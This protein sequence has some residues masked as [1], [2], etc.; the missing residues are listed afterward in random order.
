MKTRR[1]H[2]VALVV[3][4]LLVGALTLI[5]GPAQAHDELVS[6]NPADRATVAVMPAQIVLTFAEAAEKVG[7]QVIVK[8]PG[9]DV[10]VGT[11]VFSGVTVTQAVQPGAPAGSYTVLWRV[12]SDDGH[13]VSG[14]FG[15]TAA[16]AAAT[17]S[18]AS[19][20]ASTAPSQGSTG[21]SGGSGGSTWVKVLVVLVLLV[22]IALFIRRRPGRRGQMSTH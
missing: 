6:T 13:P 16:A 21:G 19:A 2:P 18:S 8:G 20:P 7:S 4:A 1:T 11:P 9:G 15:F 3:G 14:T 17:S 12:T 22:P 10:A 5:N